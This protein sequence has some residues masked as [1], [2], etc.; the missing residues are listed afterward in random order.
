[1]PNQSWIKIKRENGNE[2]YAPVSRSKFYPEQGAKQLAKRKLA[3]SFNVQSGVCSTQEGHTLDQ[4][5]ESSNDATD[6]SK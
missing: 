1:M 2:D 5:Y 4:L 6:S 3:E